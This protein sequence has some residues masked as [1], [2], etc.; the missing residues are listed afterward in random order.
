VKLSQI[1][2]INVAMLSVLSIFCSVPVQSQQQKSLEE[3]EVPT[4]SM[5]IL[6]IH[7][8]EVDAR[9]Y[10]LTMTVKP[11]KAVYTVGEPVNIN[12]TIQNNSGWYFR[13][14]SNCTNRLE[15]I[16]PEYQV[17]DESGHELPFTKATKQYIDRFL[18]I[19]RLHK[20]GKWAPGLWIMCDSQTRFT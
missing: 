8:E 12:I 2:R 10:G 4:E 18:E 19:E 17:L 15:E 6:I 1:F 7:K 13:G 5:G 9:E 11:D 3:S 20:L 14:S 16:K